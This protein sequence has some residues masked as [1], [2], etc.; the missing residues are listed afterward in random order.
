MPNFLYTA[1]DESGQKVNGSEQGASLDEVITRLQ[2]KGMLVINIAPEEK[3]AALP[4]AVIEAQAKSKFRPKH[5]RVTSEDLVLFCRQIST[6]LGAGVTI[7]RSLDIIAQQVSS[8][9]F[10]AVIK[11]LQKN[12]DRKSVV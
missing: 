9:R 5:N 6:L 10:Q 11:D 8:R 3:G 4:H 7:L 2:A 1:R 12:I